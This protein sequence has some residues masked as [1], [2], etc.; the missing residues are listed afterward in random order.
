MAPTY[1]PSNNSWTIL[2]A[3]MSSKTTVFGLQTMGPTHGLWSQ[4]RAVGLN[5]DPRILS[6]SWTH[7]RLVY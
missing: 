5:F 6:K 2:L 7:L 3:S 4:R 1:S